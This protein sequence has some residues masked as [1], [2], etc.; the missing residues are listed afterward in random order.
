MSNLDSG[1]L[2]KQNPSRYIPVW[3]LRFFCFRSNYLFYFKNENDSTSQGFVD[4]RQ[5]TSVSNNT[6]VTP[7]HKKLCFNL[8]TKKRTY[9][10][11]A[12]SEKL[13]KQWIHTIEN[14]I[15]LLIGDPEKE[16]TTIEGEL[17]QLIKR[18]IKKKFVKERCVLYSQIP[19]LVHYQ[20][21]NTKKLHKKPFVHLEKIVSCTRVESKKSSR[22]NIFQL[23]GYDRNYFFKSTKK[24]IMD[25][26]LDSIN[27]LLQTDKGNNQSQNQ[28]LEPESE[29]EKEKEK[30]KEK[31]PESEN[32]KEKEKEKESEKEKEKE[33][34]NEMN[35]KGMGIKNKNQKLQPKNQPIN[36]KN[37]NNEKTKN[38]NKAINGINSNYEGN[39]LLSSSP[40]TGY[41]NMKSLLNNNS[42]FIFSEN[43]EG[44]LIEIKISI[45]SKN[46]ESEKLI[47]NR[48]LTILENLKKISDQITVIKDLSKLTAIIPGDYEN[49]IYPVLLKNEELLKKY[50]IKN[51]E[52]IEL[53]DK[54]YLNQSGIEMPLL[55]KIL[56][57]PLNFVKG[58]NVT[59]DLTV[60]DLKNLLLKKK[61][62]ANEQINSRSIYISPSYRFPLGLKMDDSIYVLSYR[63]S[64]QDQLEIK[65]TITE[66]DEVSILKNIINNCKIYGQ[67]TLQ[68]H[69]TTKLFYSVISPP[70]LELY[71]NE[72]ASDPYLTLYLYNLEVI[73]LPQTSEDKK[74]GRFAFDLEYPIKTYHFT[75]DSKKSKLFWI[76][77]LKWSIKIAEFKKAFV[78]GE[79]EG[80]TLGF[81]INRLEGNL[82]MIQLSSKPYK[83]RKMYCQIIDSKIFCYTS[84]QQ[85]KKK[86]ES[87]ASLEILLVKILT[88]KPNAEL[89][90]KV[91]KELGLTKNE[92]ESAFK[93]IE[94]NGE[95]YIFLADGIEEKLK[96]TRGIDILRYQLPENLLLDLTT[97][98]TTTTTASSSTGNITD[99]EEE[100][101]DEDD[102]DDENDEDNNSDED[103]EIEI[104]NND[105]NDKETK[106]T[107]KNIKNQNNKKKKKIKKKKKKKSQEVK[108]H[109]IFKLINSNETIDQYGKDLPWNVIKVGDSTEKIE[110]I[111]HMNDSML[112]SLLQEEIIN[113]VI[114]TSD[115]LKN[116]KKILIRITPLLDVERVAFIKES[117]RHD[118]S[119]IAL[120]NH[121][122]NLV[123]VQW[124]GNRTTRIQKAKAKSIVDQMA[125]NT[126]SQQQQQQQQQQQDHFQNN[127]FFYNSNNNVNLNSKTLFKNRTNSLTKDNNNFLHKRNKSARFNIQEK[128]K[129]SPLSKKTMQKTIN[130]EKDLINLKKQQN[131]LLNKN[132]KM[133][134]DLENIQDENQKIRSS[135]I[136]IKKKSLKN[137]K[138]STKKK[139]PTHLSGKLSV[140][141]KKNKPILIRDQSLYDDLDFFISL[142]RGGKGPNDKNLSSSSTPSLTSTLRSSKMS[143]SNS[144]TFTRHYLNEPLH[145]RQDSN[146]KDDDLNLNNFNNNLDNYSKNH[147]IFWSQ[148]GLTEPLTKLNEEDNVSK[149][150]KKIVKLYR[151]SRNKFRKIECVKECKL[152]KLKYNSLESNFCYILDSNSEIFLWFGNFTTL[153]Q[154]K[155]TTRLA[156][157]IKY[158][159]KRKTP[160]FAF[161]VLDKREHV[162]FTEKFEDSKTIFGI[163]NDNC[164]LLNQNNSSDNKL[165]LNNNINSNS[166]SQLELYRSDEELILVNLFNK[167]VIQW[168]ENLIQSI[169]TNMKINKQKNKFEKEIRFIKDLL[170]KLN[171]EKVELYQITLNKILK[172]NN[173]NIDNLNNLDYIFQLLF[174]NIIEDNEEEEEEEEEEENKDEAK[175][176][177]IN[178]DIEI[179][180]Y[181]TE[182]EELIESDLDM[183]G[184][185]FS[186][187]IY[188]VIDKSIYSSVQSNVTFD[189]T[190]VH[191]WKGRDTENLENFN[192]DS[193]FN[194]ELPKSAKN[195]DIQFRV[196]QQRENSQFINLFDNKL[197]IHKSKN[198]LGNPNN[199]LYQIRK[200]KLSGGF[201]AI[202]VDPISNWLNP[203]DCF[204]L[205]CDQ[206][207]YLWIG[208]FFPEQDLIQAKI[209]VNK[210]QGEEILFDNNVNID[211]DK[212][213]NQE[214]KKKKNDVTLE[215]INQILM[216]SGVIEIKEGNEPKQFWDNLTHQQNYFKDSI[217]PL[218]LNFPFSLFIISQNLETLNNDDDDDDDRD[219]IKINN[220][221]KEGKKKQ[222]NNNNNN[223]NNSSNENNNENNNNN[224]NTNSVS[225][226]TIF[227]TNYFIQDDLGENETALLISDYDGIFIWIGRS[228]TTLHKKIS[229]KLAQLFSK[230]LNL[231]IKGVINSFDE[232]L[233]FSRYFHGWS[234]SKFPEE[235]KSP[236][237]P[238]IQENLILNTQKYLDQIETSSKNQILSYHSLLQ[239]A[240]ELLDKEKPNL[241]KL[242]NL[243]I[244]NL[245]QINKNKLEEYLI[246]SD[247]MELFGISREEFN[248][249]S[250]EQ[251][252]IIKKDLYLL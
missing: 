119:F 106:K 49:S 190:I 163:K 149:R 59:Q 151:I 111:L 209:L 9:V 154:R 240:H 114:N 131:T 72:N 168:V 99:D 21:G 3:K 57:H 52:V 71:L 91:I 4:L 68:V 83:F 221:Q 147:L 100:D 88:V 245:N 17:F 135:P 27:S 70:F 56:L 64:K 63:F 165:L 132:N 55:T 249:F 176:T 54:F 79:E 242:K 193:F 158:Q 31:E 213:G 231:K 187:E 136:K 44:E 28:I 203:W 26:W 2:Y 195:A 220:N 121:V 218:N 92:I 161:I 41:K 169:L 208:K 18:G 184:H 6:E 82:M 85:L 188:V 102:D 181:D 33:D 127:Q 115:L 7:R 157:A 223:N 86:N 185:F 19:A 46:Y 139:Y 133:S 120:F 20:E 238:S 146:S 197:I 189:E 215:E 47:F 62:I 66:M 15:K 134:K 8:S 75:T 186:H 73:D 251:K 137:N 234:T 94:K 87:S 239:I 212:N 194:T 201:Q 22:K 65:E 182:L 103:D 200:H 39:G 248:L 116:N 141:N 74:S 226:F 174:K 32:E 80:E 51:G 14:R 124:N 107:K 129:L 43:E 142:S 140:P 23:E 175:K 98:T 172:E 167:M 179:W 247:F 178:K 237:S 60:L 198:K 1:W 225:E 216:D 125:E 126:S 148:F 227:H 236:P 159:I 16:P 210:L 81:Q 25:K 45:P 214:H 235:K 170:I 40:R 233:M 67:L 78:T 202:E 138:K 145:N 84:K 34:N 241:D 224:N 36:I 171:K 152:N 97:N 61:L 35:N 232:P 29:S 164:N 244:I 113:V 90:S 191:Y 192:F 160:S 109:Q 95:E 207:A 24:E 243:G 10:L 5:V 38:S 42:N 199:Y 219:D 30:E 230:E 50:H 128:K 69:T 144:F 153:A 101:D 118:C 229:L 108:P 110:T 11:R 58:V 130:S 89:S 156:R 123:F 246:D 196:T 183:M 96:W 228:S 12:T 37:R 211:F 177:L 143:S 104:L 162:L 222:E 53:L 155:L 122:N 206:A 93:I 252:K 217:N 105:D 180:Q 77:K 76:E 48:N 117:L 205:H 173:L 250:E 112:G 204:L 166:N 13:C 150:E